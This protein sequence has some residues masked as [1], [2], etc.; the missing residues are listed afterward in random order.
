MLKRIFAIVTA[1]VLTG[2]FVI[3]NQVPASASAR[4]GALHV[5]KEC[6]H[7][8]GAAGSFCTITGSNLKSI[9]AN[10]KVVYATAANAD[11]SLISD[12]TIYSGHNKIY[13]HV[14]LTSAGMWVT[15]SG[16]TGKFRHFAA[17]AVV[18]VDSTGL[19]HWDGTY[20]FGD[21]HDR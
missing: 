9:K 15:L 20:R 11:G 4:G 17:K 18:S 13:G 1:V 21:R 3:A 12:I 14:S 5:T 16:G 10:S 8:T 19:W 7:Y 2:G 6:S